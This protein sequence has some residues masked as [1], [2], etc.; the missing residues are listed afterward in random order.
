M[1]TPRVVLDLS[2]RYLRNSNSIFPADPNQISLLV[3]GLALSGRSTDL[4]AGEGRQ[5]ESHDG[6]VTLSFARGKHS[7]RFGGTFSADRNRFQFPAFEAGRAIVPG[8]AALSMPTPTADLFQLGS[9]G[10]E[11]GFSV[12]RTELFVQDDYKVLS[13]LTLSYGLRYK[14]E[15]P[16]SFQEDDLQGWQPRVGLAANL[17]SGQKTTFRASYG[18]FRL[19]FPQRPQAYQL[20]LG[21]QGLRAGVPTP[22]RTVTS[23]IG[24]PAASNALASFLSTGTIPAGPQLAVTSPPFLRSAYTQT[25]GASLERQIGTSWVVGGEYAYTAG[26]H[27]LTATNRNLGPPSLVAGRP[28]F[29][30]AILSPNFAQ[31]YEF[32]SA[33]TSRYHGFSAT[34]RRSSS[35]GFQLQARYTFSRTI[36]DV[37]GR[38]FET[39]EATPENVFNRGGDRA[40]SEWNRA[41]Y[42]RADV[43]F[44]LALPTGQS[45]SRFR[46]SLFGSGTL[47]FQSGRDFNVL[48]GFDANHDGNPLT[49]RP[50]NVGRNT[51]LGQHFLQVDTRVGLHFSWGER[52][53]ARAFADV[54]NLFNRTNFLTFQTTL[55]QGDLTG[56]DPR[57]VSGR[58]QVPSYDYRQPLAPSG[59]G[60]GASAGS[61]RR[62]QLGMKFEF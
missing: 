13:R 48:A 12:S 60:L 34:V 3:S 42:F 41:H 52:W 8:L 43:P 55:G 56:L 50:L 47:R 27:L 32:Q 61:P 36:D 59:F 6:S 24:D 49:D 45:F 37:P 17:D 11:V 30:G 57:I 39:F 38:G 10:A 16:P 14:A 5:Q 35:K 18:L 28:D 62:F 51:F 4:L 22:V 21:G 20:L 15:F 1:I 40:V 9:G 44:D 53:S 58:R 19:P 29:L 31:I 23:F 46:W 25:A 33:G 54:F 2:Y 7:L 26:T